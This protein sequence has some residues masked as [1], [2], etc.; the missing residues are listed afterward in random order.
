MGRRIATLLAPTDLGAAG[1]KTIDI[2]LKEQISRIFLVWT[3]TNV[4]VSVMLDEIMACLSRIELVDG[5][6]VKFSATGKEAQGINYCDSKVMPYSYAPLAVGGIFRASCAL[7]FGRFLWDPIFALRPGT[8]KNPQLKITWDEDACNTAVVVNSLSVYACVDDMPTGGGASGY[9]KTREVYQ[10]NMAAS[11]HEYVDLP[12]DYPIRKVFVQSLSTDHDTPDLLDNLTIDV[13]QGRHIP[14]D[15]N[16]PNYCD[17]LAMEYPDVVIPVCLDEVVTAKTLIVP[18][19]SHN[20]IAISYDGTAFVTA[21]S[22]FAVP[23]FQGQVIALAASVTIQADTGIVTGRLPQGVIPVDF[24]DPNEPETWMQVSGLNNI[25]M[26]ILA[27]ADA[28]VGDA[29]R[30]VTQQSVMY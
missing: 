24:G 17:Y 30:V 11:G 20:R 10:Y 6:D 18:T 4:T 22:L 7:N 29:T 2:N 8:M 15:I 13:E 14:L 28:D 5:S 1:T 3:C 25:R 9:I 26:D 12:T 23:T 16:V 19:A 21:T 27:S